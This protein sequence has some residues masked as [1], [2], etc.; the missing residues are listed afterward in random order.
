MLLQCSWIRSGDWNDLLDGVRALVWRRPEDFSV[1][2][3]FVLL[4]NLEVPA[5][6]DR[7]VAQL[8][9]PGEVRVGVLGSGELG[10][11]VDARVELRRAMPSVLVVAL[12]ALAEA[13]SQ[14]AQVPEA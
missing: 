11:R 1:A 4:T 7:A 12:N 13:A 14:L 9:G 6:C 8:V 10:A 2:A 5:W 3:S